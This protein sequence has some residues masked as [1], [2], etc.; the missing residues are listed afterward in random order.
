MCQKWSM[1]LFI[2]LTVFVFEPNNK[3]AKQQDDPDG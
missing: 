2:T 1:A 3:H